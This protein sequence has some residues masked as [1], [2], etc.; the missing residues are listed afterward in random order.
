MAAYKLLLDKKDENKFVDIAGVAAGAFGA[1]GF[2]F[3][4]QKG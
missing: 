2:D 4:I 1:R 3:S